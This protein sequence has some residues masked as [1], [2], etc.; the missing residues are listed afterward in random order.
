MGKYETMGLMKRVIRPPNFEINFF[1]VLFIN[2]SLHNYNKG[3]TKCQLCVLFSKV[4]QGHWISRTQ[5]VIFKRPY[6]CHFMTYY[7]L[8]RLELCRTIRSMIF[9]ETLKNKTSTLQNLP[10]TSKNLPST[11]LKLAR[12]ISRIY[13]D[14][15]RK[16]IPKFWKV[17][18]R[19]L[20]VQT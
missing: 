8:W 15:H 3:F 4:I 2:Y 6:T 18:G 12:I 17:L 9:L 5:Y 13:Q 14:R 7:R 11:V 1:F 19:Y 10:K 16:V 20:R